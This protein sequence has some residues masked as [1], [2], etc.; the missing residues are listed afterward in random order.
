MIGIGFDKGCYVGTHGF[1]S[2]TETSTEASI[3]TRR[4]NAE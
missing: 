1:F 3:S 2:P 4:Q